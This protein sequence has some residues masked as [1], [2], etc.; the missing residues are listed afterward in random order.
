MVVAATSLGF[1]V[2]QLDV[3]IVN[4]ALARHRAMRSAPASEACNGWST[5]IRSPSPRSC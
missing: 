2:V 3:S 4:V 5:P 1:V